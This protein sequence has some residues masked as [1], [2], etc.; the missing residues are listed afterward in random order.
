MVID[1]EIQGT[2]ARLDARIAKLKKIRDMLVEE[3]AVADGPTVHPPD[4]SDGMNRK[5]QVALFLFNNGP[6]GR[7]EIIAELGVPIGTAAYVLNDK[8]IFRN[9]G[10]VWSLTEEQVNKM[11]SL[12]T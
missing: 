4:E 7:K 12:G 5:Q 1:T 9:E 3:F 11:K 2:I 10:G 6:K 8:S